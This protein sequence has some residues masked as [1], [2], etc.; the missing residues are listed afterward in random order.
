M[1]LVG[2]GTGY[3][4]LIGGRIGA[5]RVAAHLVDEADDGKAPRDDDREDRG[6]PVHADA[7]FAVSDGDPAPEDGVGIGACEAL[8]DVFLGRLVLFRRH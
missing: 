6:D 8:L 2:S 5:S 7:E 1:R 4:G 3:G